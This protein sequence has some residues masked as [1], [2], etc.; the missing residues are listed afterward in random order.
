MQSAE[1]CLQEAPLK[2]V[3]LTMGFKESK[4]TDLHNGLYGVNWR[5]VCRVAN[6]SMPWLLGGSCIPLLGRN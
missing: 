4:L 5:L 2:E 1:P 6:L 3:L